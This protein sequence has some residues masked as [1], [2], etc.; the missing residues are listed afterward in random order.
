MGNVIRK[1]AIN[2]LS[3]YLGVIIG[4]VNL[5]ILFPRAFAER[6]DLFGLI[7]LIIS[8]GLVVSSFT[9]L[10]IPRVI[11]R[12]FPELEKID[13]GKLLSFLTF[14]PLP[15]LLL[16][17]STLFL[18]D[19]E[20]IPLLNDD[21]LFLENWVYLIPLTLFY[22]YFEILGSLS[23]SFNNTELPL[24]L[25]EVMRRLLMSILIVL[26]WMGTIDLQWF[27]LL[28]II[29]LFAQLFVLLFYMVKK[30]F[31][32]FNLTFKYRFN[33]KAMLVY[34]GFVFLTTG[35]NLLI[36][37]ID[38]LM[39]GSLMSLEKVA[40]YS[41]AFFMGAVL[42]VPGKS[43]IRT[44]QPILS[45]AFARDDMN[46]VKQIYQAT[47]NNLLIISSLLF[48]LLV[49]NV[50]DLLFFLPAKFRGA[51]QVVFFIALG[52]L[53]NTAAGQNGEV[54]TLSKYYKYNIWFLSFL[55]IATIGSNFVFI[56]LMGIEGAALA[57]FI[58]LLSF[59]IIKG[60]FVKVKMDMIP[61]EKKSLL[62]F[63][64]FALCFLVGYF[65]QLNITLTLR[66]FL[67]T[68]LIIALFLPL[69]YW[70]KLSE[71]INGLLKKVLRYVGFTV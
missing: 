10:G 23:A 62:I 13:K 34:G 71:E 32:V 46:K 41:V 44:T 17:T 47:A 40:Y 49:T 22:V 42:A 5:L 4:A 51:E 9:N 20:L 16:L 26:Y 28:M 33:L 8:Y 58:S 38:L 57:T 69:V 37:K 63:P 39:I 68:T 53:A 35:I 56:P 70:L 52:Q 64:L 18:F 43:L 48:I 60:I 6:P 24:F 59:N 15:V 30:G 2:A 27:F 14:Y 29:G 11:I 3:N 31:F 45:N 50:H 7:Q 67:R 25:K 55:L 19:D 65:F 12:Y 61:L 36:N 1:S 66:I 54:I 21:P